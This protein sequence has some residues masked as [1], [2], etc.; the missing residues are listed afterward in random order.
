MSI[1]NVLLTS[2]FDAVTNPPRT[3]FTFINI[4]FDEKDIL[5]DSFSRKLNNQINLKTN[6]S[7]DHFVNGSNLL[8]K[9]KASFDWVWETA[10][11]DFVEFRNEDSFF[12]IGPIQGF[13][14]IQIDKFVNNEQSWW[15]ITNKMILK[16]S[17]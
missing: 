4:D 6:E 7:S 1:F 13:Y 2:E 10:D 9:L 15:S 11:D 17:C 5:T 12:N 8:L 3:F 16:E 14:D